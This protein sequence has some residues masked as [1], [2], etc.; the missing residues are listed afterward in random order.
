MDGL[1]TAVGGEIGDGV[2]LAVH[3]DEGGL[4]G[5]MVGRERGVETLLGLA[6]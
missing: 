3:R 1:A 5:W 4:G 2:W 6:E